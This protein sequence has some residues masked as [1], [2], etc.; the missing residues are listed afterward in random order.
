MANQSKLQAEAD[1][2]QYIYVLSKLGAI[3][4]LHKHSGLSSWTAKFLLI[5]D[6]F[7]SRVLT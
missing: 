1:S 3:R 6:Y 5:N 2:S 4:R 7:F